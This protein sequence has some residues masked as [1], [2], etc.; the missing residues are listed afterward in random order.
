M[1]RAI[2]FVTGAA[3]YV[4]TVAGP[5]YADDAYSYC[6]YYASTA[7]RAGH[8]ARHVDACQHLVD[9][10]PARWTLNYDQHFNWCL[11]MFG[12]GRNASEHQ[13]RNAQ[14][15]ECGAL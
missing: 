14:L 5:A 9:D 4:M 13:V 8:I 3:L 10:F 6:H 2:T 7:V 12:S 15:V 1:K 11:S